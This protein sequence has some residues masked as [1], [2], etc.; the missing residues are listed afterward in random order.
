[1]KR[2][3]DLS[4]G[5]TRAKDHPPGPQCVSVCVVGRGHPDFHPGFFG[6]ALV[7]APGLFYRGTLRKPVGETEEILIE[8]ASPAEP[9][10]ARGRAESAVTKVAVH[11]IDTGFFSFLPVEHNL[12]IHDRLLPNMVF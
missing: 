5:T 12:D 3:N 8:L 11:L 6:W 1:M 7:E 2:V 4:Q 10:K 9:V